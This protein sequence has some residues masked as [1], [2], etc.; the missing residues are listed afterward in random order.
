MWKSL[1]EVRARL[2]ELLGQIES[3]SVVAARVESRHPFNAQNPADSVSFFLEE[4]DAFFDDSA[5]EN[6][7]REDLAVPEFPVLP[8]SEKTF[9]EKLESDEPGAN[10]V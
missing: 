9:V 7:H 6:C 5:D 10:F 3:A 4:C 8:T 2:D 1:R